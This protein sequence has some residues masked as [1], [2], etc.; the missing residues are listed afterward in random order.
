MSRAFIDPTLQHGSE[1]DFLILTEPAGN[2]Q[3]GF[4]LF[5]VAYRVDLDLTPASRIAIYRAE[6]RFVPVERSGLAFQAEKP[7][8]NLKCFDRSGWT[9]TKRFTNRVEALFWIDQVIRPVRIRWI[10]QMAQ[11]VVYEGI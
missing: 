4:E 5:R 3:R 8:L 10:A 1:S 9:I 11:V 7:I 2:R 6:G